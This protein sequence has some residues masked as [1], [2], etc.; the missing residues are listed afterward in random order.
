MR[1]NSP[2]QKDYKMEIDYNERC[3][4]FSQPRILRTAEDYNDWVIFLMMDATYNNLSISYYGAQ[5]SQDYSIEKISKEIAPNLPYVVVHNFTFG[6]LGTV[7]HIM[8]KYF[9]YQR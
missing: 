2:W 3:D 9:L 5:N 4:F 6:Y 8:D 1:Y 7:V